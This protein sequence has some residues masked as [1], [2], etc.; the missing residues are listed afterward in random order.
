VRGSLLQA[1]AR[2]DAFT[3]RLEREHGDQLMCGSGCDDC[4]RQTLELRG[5]E[6][7]YL[8]EGTRELSQEAVSL[9]WH[10][11]E[12]A[13]DRCPLLHG[14]LCLSYDHRPAIC[15]THGLALLRRE[16]GEAVLHHC[17]KNFGDLDPRA[18]PRSL[19]LDEERV[20]LLMD[21]VDA[22]YCRQAGWPGVRIDVRAL[23]RSGLLP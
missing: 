17:P 14:G 3:G 11:L 10:S 8:L 20:V 12:D 13:A 21:A 2:V 4:C 5:V 1:L 9:I 16:A 22:L 15:R 7:A 23:L 19:I 18:L 6:A